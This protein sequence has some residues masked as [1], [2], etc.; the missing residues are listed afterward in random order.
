MRKVAPA[1]LEPRSGCAVARE[2]KE[3]PKDKGK[4]IHLSSKAN[5]LADN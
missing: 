5:M 1:D 2:L 4:A 3:T